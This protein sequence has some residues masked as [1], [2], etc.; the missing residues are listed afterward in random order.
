[1][2]SIEEEKLFKARFE[3]HKDQIFRLCLG[4]FQQDKELAEDALQETF[5]KAWVHRKQFRADA[6]WQT[7]IYRIAV[8]TCLFQLKKQK[9]EQQ[10]QDAFS[11]FPP[12]EYDAEKEQKIQKMY[13]CINQLSPQNRILIL[14]V[15]EGIPY[16][17]I[18]ET[19]GLSPE[20]L[21]VKIHR[22]KKQ[23]YPCITDG[24]L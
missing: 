23:L 3:E 12:E 2:N 4:Y 10:N 7:W 16:A 14:M 24:K 22:I 21:R 1:L 8:N 17:T 15:L 18:E 19:L 6:N 9:K 11:S 13:A 20:N 5:I